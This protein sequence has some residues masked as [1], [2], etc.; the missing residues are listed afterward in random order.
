MGGRRGVQT[1]D[2]FFGYGDLRIVHQVSVAGFLSVSYGEP[3]FESIPVRKGETI[4]FR[5]RGQIQIVQL[6]PGEHYG[7]SGRAAK[8]SHSVN[9]RG[10]V[11]VVLECWPPCFPLLLDYRFDDQEDWRP[12]YSSGPLIALN[13]PD[14]VDS[15]QLRCLERLTQLE[16]QLPA[17]P[18][19]Q[20]VDNLFELQLERFTAKTLSVAESKLTNLLMTNRFPRNSSNASTR[21]PIEWDLRDVTPM[22]IVRRLEKAYDVQLDWDRAESR[23]K[24][25][26]PAMNRI[27][28]RLERFYYKHLP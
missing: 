8:R 18:G 13:V 27:R 1:K 26:D 16:F 2:S 17:I 14:E 24:L 9:G 28:T 19:L 10:Y 25:H 11:G 6:A 23:F 20:D 22:D 15:V 12:V 4:R 21:A 7:S 3:I 5:D